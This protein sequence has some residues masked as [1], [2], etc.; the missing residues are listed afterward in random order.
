MEK[1]IK[2]AKQLERHFKGVANHHRVNILQLIAKQ[3]GISVEGIAENLGANIKTISEHTRKL[4]LAGLVDKKYQGRVVS[5]ALSPYG[6]IFHA[7][8]RTF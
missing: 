2:S 8:I 7:F 5:R 6:K 1:K 3:E 4:V